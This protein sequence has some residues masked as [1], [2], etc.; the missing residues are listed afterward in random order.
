MAIYGDGKHDSGIIAKSKRKYTRRKETGIYKP[1][2]ITT[3][4]KADILGLKRQNKDGNVIPMFKKSDVMKLN[5]SDMER[6]ASKLGDDYCEQLFWG[7]LEIITEYVLE[8][9]NKEK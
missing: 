2:Q 9:K 1:F 6:I 3:V 8:N 5:S 7:S 4:C